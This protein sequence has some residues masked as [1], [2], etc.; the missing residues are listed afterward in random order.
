M[1]EWK[2]EDIRLNVEDDNLTAK[3]FYSRLGFISLA[4]NAELIQCPTQS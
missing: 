2:C 1:E 4:G 3:M